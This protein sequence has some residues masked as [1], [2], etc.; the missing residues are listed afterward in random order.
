MT[1]QTIEVSQYNIAVPR[2]FLFS[3]PRRRIGPQKQTARLL[4]R[5]RAVMS[6]S[7]FMGLIA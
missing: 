5:K 1:L 7:G 3:A 6:P 4:N 2:R